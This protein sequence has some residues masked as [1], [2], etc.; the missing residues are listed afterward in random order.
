LDPKDYGCVKVISKTCM[1][2]PTVGKIQVEY[3][4]EQDL[5]SNSNVRLEVF[6]EIDEL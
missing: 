6:N 4:K 2:S 1:N 5:N 3:R